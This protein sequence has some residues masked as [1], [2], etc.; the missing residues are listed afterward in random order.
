MKIEVAYN[1]LGRISYRMNGM[2]YPFGNRIRDI[3]IN[4][5]LSGD[6]SCHPSDGSALHPYGFKPFLIINTKGE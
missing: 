3:D 1:L 6:A 4:L 5:I 2:I